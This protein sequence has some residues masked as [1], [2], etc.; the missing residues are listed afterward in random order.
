VKDPRGR[1]DRCGDAKFEGRLRLATRIR[2]DAHL[3]ILAL[4]SLATE[5]DMAKR[6]AA[7][8]DDYQIKLRR[9]NLLLSLP[10]LLAARD[11]DGLG[12]QAAA[13][14]LKRGPARRDSR[15]ET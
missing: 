13:C 1:G 9:D 15:E 10:A 8:M 6:K 11:E 4:T 5:E 7:G 12:R 14:K 2:Q 3:P